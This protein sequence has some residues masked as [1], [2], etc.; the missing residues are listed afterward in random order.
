LV[1]SVLMGLTKNPSD[2]DGLK[3]DPVPF[4]T[5]E[6]VGAFA[7]RPMATEDEP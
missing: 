6:F 3:A 7:S 2:V 5:T 1:E 4:R